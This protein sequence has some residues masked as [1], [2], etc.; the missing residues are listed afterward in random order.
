MLRMLTIMTM[1]GTPAA[2]VAAPCTTPTN[3][4]AEWITLG[5]G[6]ARSLVYRSYPLTE[7]NDRI[8]RAVVIVHGSDRDAEGY[9]QIGVAAARLAGALNDTIVIAPK[10]A[11]TQ[12]L[13][14]SPDWRVVY[15]DGVAVVFRRN[16]GVPAS[17]VSSGEGKNRDRAITKTITSDHTVT[18]P[19]T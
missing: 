14:I 19:T 4:C 10:F 17:L 7:R 3:L 15:D 16:P 12:T 13:K 6:P 9:F 5:D 18:Q 11:L 1:L 8:R 2:A